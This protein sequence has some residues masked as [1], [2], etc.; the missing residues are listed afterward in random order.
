MKGMILIA[1]FVL[2]VACSTQRGPG[3]LFGPSEA[4]V[5]VVDAL[6]IV[7]RP[8]PDLF[9]HE[10]V[11]PGKRYTRE[12]AAVSGAAVEVLQGDLVFSYSADPDSAG[13]YLPPAERPAVMPTTEY[14][15]VVR[16][17][18]RELRATTRTPAPFQIREVVLLD[19]ET[20]E[21]RR[22]LKT[23]Q[24]G[25]DVVF[26]AP[27]NQVT[28]LDGLLEARFDPIDV[29]GYQAGIFSIDPGSER[30]LEADFLDEEDYA[31][32]EPQG[33]SPAFVAPD[34]RLRLPWFVVAF[35]GRTILRI[36]ALDKN[37]FDFVRSSPEN[38]GGNFG[39]LAGDNFDRPLFRTEGGLGLFGSAAVDSLGFVVLPRPED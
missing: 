8:L 30:V 14:H 7:G 19:E 15:L 21:V 29:S 9:L 16:S 35:A 38:E 20:Q 13:R 6:L 18:G 28:Y 37:W 36:Y 24:E 39:N 23:F 22:H 3:E 2:M 11:A 17:D 33:S 5:L 26:T 12:A 25:S 34:G 32:L 4:G 31:D 1:G 10:T 27:E